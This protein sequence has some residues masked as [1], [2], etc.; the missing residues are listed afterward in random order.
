MAPNLADIVITA[1]HSLHGGEENWRGTDE[2]KRLELT[3]EKL[4][5]IMES[6]KEKLDSL[7]SA[8]R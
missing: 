3:E 1:K 6:Y 2:A 5:A 7:A 4:P 8:V